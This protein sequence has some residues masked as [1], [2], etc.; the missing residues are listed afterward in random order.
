MKKRL[1]ALFL[2][3]IMTVTAFPGTAMA[4]GSDTEPANGDTETPGDYSGDV[5]RYAQFIP[6]PEDEETGG[7]YV[8]REG[9]DGENWSLYYTDFEEGTVLR[10]T[11]WSVDSENGLWYQV[12]LFS[13][14]VVP[15]AAEYWPEDPWI[16]QDYLDESYDWD[17]VLEFIPCP[18]CGGEDCT[19]EHVRCP[20][21]GEWDCP[22]THAYCG[23]CGEL[24]CG[25]Q[26][27]YCEIC[28]DFDCGLEHEVPPVEVWTPATAPVIPETPQL[29]DTYDVAILDADGRP[30]TGDS[31]ILLGW[32]EQT[33]ISAW[34]VL[35]EEAS[36][37]WQIFISEGD[38]FWVDISGQTGKGLLF[39]RAMLM[40]A[41]DDSGCTWLRCVTALEGEAMTSE[42]VQVTVDI[43]EEE[44][45][46]ENTGEEPVLFAM[47]T[48]GLSRLSAQDSGIATAAAD[49]VTITIQYLDAA[50]FVTG[51]AQTPVTKPYV[52]T[53][54]VGEPFN[55]TVLAPSRPGYAPFWD[56]DGDNQLWTGADYYTR[57]GEFV[58]G[59][60]PGTDESAVQ[61][62]L[63]LTGDQTTEDRVYYVY[64]LP[65]EVNVGVRYFFQNVDNDGYTEDISLYHQDRMRTG[66]I[67]TEAY[68]Q[69]CLEEKLGE[70]LV[71]FTR[72]VHQSEPVA[73]DGSTVFECYYDREYFMMQF[74]LSGG[75]GVEPIYARFETP[76]SLPDPTRPGYHFRGWDLMTADTND[77]GIPDAGDDHED[78]LPAAVPA[79]NLRYTAIWAKDPDGVT[80]TVVYWRENADPEPD[81]TYG[82]SFWGSEQ[83]RAAA[84]VTVSGSDSVPTSIS[85]AEIDGDPVDEK[86]FFTYNDARTDKNVV[87]A[88]DGSTIVNVYYTRNSY[89]IQFKGYGKCALSTHTHGTGCVC[90]QE[91]HTHTNEC[92]AVVVAC[93]LEEHQ[94]TAECLECAHECDTG[95]FT[96]G[97]N[98]RVLREINAPTGVTATSDGGG[99]IYTR[100]QGNTTYYYLKLGET[101]Y[102][103][104]RNNTSYPT[105]TITWTCSHGNNHDA[106]CYKDIAHTHSDACYGYECG[107]AAHTHSTSC[108]TITAHT[109]N[110]T[111]N[112]NSTSN[113]VYV[114]TAKYNADISDLWPTYDVLKNSSTHYQDADGNVEYNNERFRGW[115]IG[116]DSTTN[117]SKRVN[118]T[119]ELCGTSGIVTASAVYDYNYFVHLYYMFES[120][121]QT[122]PANGTT[123]LAYTHNGVTKFY[124]SDP[125]YRQDVY[126]GSSQFSA[127]EIMGMT[128]IAVVSERVSG[129]EYNNWLYYDRVSHTLRFQNYGDIWDAYTETVKYGVPLAEYAP[130]TE[131][132]YPSTLEPEA[133]QFDGWY[134][135]PGCVPGT[136]ADFDTEIMPDSDMTYYAS[137]VKVSH[138]VRFF[139]HYEYLAAWLEGETTIEHGDTVID[140]TADDT[141]GMKVDTVIHGHLVTP[142]IAEEVLHWTYQLG[143]DNTAQLFGLF[144]MENGQKKAFDLQ[145]IPVRDDLNIYVEWRG[146]AEHPYRIEYVLATDPTEVVAEPTTGYSRLGVL[147]TFSAK[148]GHQ[149][150]PEYITGYFPLTASHS[151]VVA[152]EEDKDTPVN[153]VYQFLYAQVTNVSYTVHYVD[154]ATGDPIP[155]LES[156]TVTTTNAVVTV[157]YEPVDGYV[158]DAFYKQ[159][160][161][162][163]KADGSGGFVGDDTKNVITFYYTKNET[164]APYA[165]HHMTE[166]LDG[167]YEEYKLD[168]AIG[169]IGS[170]VT[171]TPLTI[172][173]FQP[174]GDNT[175]TFTVQ[176]G[177][178]EL[179]VYYQRQKYHYTV[180]YYQQDTTTPVMDS[181]TLLGPALYGAP[182]TETAPLYDNGYAWKRISAE[183]QSIDIRPNDD[184]NEIV[185]YY[186]PI[187]YQVDY[188]A[189]PAEGGGFSPAS[190]E[191][192]ASQN[193]QGATPMPAPNYEFEGWYLDEACTQKVTAGE[194]TVDVDTGKLIPKGRAD[195]DG[196]PVTSYVFYAKFKLLAADF[197]I[198]KINAQPGQIFVYRVVGD[199]GF[200][201]DVT[202]QAGANGDGF[203]TIGKLPYGNYS[204]TPQT[205]WSWRYTRGGQQS[206]FH[207]G[208]PENSTV[209][210][211]DGVGVTRWLSGISNLV[212][213]IFSGE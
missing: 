213:R 159:L 118:M 67:V 39:S 152:A 7:I 210:F 173:G 181:Q 72:M 100:R 71:G 206:K 81:G 135:T 151:M 36:Y 123:R 64:Y 56:V 65:V 147:R 170:K 75:Y 8:V 106:S 22:L 175:Y 187:Q 156:R 145:N 142:E 12:D 93:G 27:I 13:G 54:P 47:R 150:F 209:T 183:S 105:T 199:N 136:E 73:S 158:P 141:D 11:D 70:P 157:S 86:P 139:R 130:T 140:F 25:E 153:N 176:K 24:N 201:L 68:L 15:E 6:D 95:C 191:V 185:F 85:V 198:E 164:D 144:Y 20:V 178:T 2:A 168:Q 34:S 14:G 122:S 186:E 134:T 74:A 37:Q 138:T 32:M 155:G 80:Y 29:P 137:W 129:N 102:C 26:H 208:T 48:F 66:T 88:G 52:A 194:G 171:V 116:N 200:R 98:N 62:V 23:V 128:N 4:A 77:D 131:P 212:K 91:A 103:A 146:Q 84:E 33:S 104:Y 112:S 120:P 167:T 41:L 3:V 211:S 79:E 161:L 16:L 61:M 196:N 40:S 28:R 17:L 184:L 174:K 83:K 192:L 69:A 44:N 163:V 42:A 5:G 60:D 149:L 89:T 10:I 110:S 99:Y 188:V 92:G 124:D 78:A 107:K 50:S 51:A 21:C 109:H 76:V 113:V 169:T 63:N 203:T 1:L 111:C 117:T 148:G 189:V 204:V 121:D 38:G 53:I 193:F 59:T 195:T 58:E 94:H 30:V 43:P 172:V 108:C 35:G 55:Q 125:A 207:D 57:D 162:S 154:K 87:V 90:P 182:V 101:W 49:T 205:S 82:Y 114:L 46:E 18:V 9:K 31:G 179:Y 115:K 45:G 19:V 132:P 119:A 127:K 197:T 190:Q 160:V 126:G 143:V 97:N 177:G 96:L 133:Y 165:V 202:V 180:H 166:K